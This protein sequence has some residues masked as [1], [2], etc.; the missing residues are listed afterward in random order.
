MPQHGRSQHSKKVI[1]CSYG[2]SPPRSGYLTHSWHVEEWLYFVHPRSVKE[3]VVG[4]IH[5]DD[6][7]SSTS[8]MLPKR[9]QWS[10]LTLIESPDDRAGAFEMVNSQPN[11]WSVMGLCWLSTRLSIITHYTDLFPKI[12]EWVS[13]GPQRLAYFSSFVNKIVAKHAIL[14]GRPTSFW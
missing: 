12:N 14:S 8:S 11:Y 13:Y 3:Y 2:P 7:E 6:Q 9:S 4:C 1:I 10:L 5:V